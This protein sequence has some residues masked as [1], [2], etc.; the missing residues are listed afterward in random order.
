MARLSLA[1]RRLQEAADE[2]EAKLAKEALRLAMPSRLMQLFARAQ[3]VNISANIKLIASGVEMTV[4]H[5]GHPHIDSTLTYDSE[6]WE[7][8]MVEDSI[9]LLKADI[10]ARNA[11]KGIAQDV[12]TNKLT[13]EERAALKEFIHSLY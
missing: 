3:G 5:D 1:E 12:W 13:P 11:R 10:D 8:E 7:V 4:Y 2:A 9:D 6:E